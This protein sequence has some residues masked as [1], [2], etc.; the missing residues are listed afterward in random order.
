ME[1]GK[2][3][4]KIL[5][6]INKTRDDYRNVKGKLFERLISAFLKNQSYRVIERLR[7]VGTEID[8]L[9]QNEL[10]S[11]KVVVEC[12]TQSEALNTA[13]INKLHTDVSLHDASN[14]WIF[15]LSDLGAEAAGRLRKLNQK[16]DNNTYKFIDA[17]ELIGVLSKCGAIR[18][19]QFETEERASEIFLCVLEHNIIWVVPSRDSTSNRP[20]GL[21]AWDA[22]NGKPIEVNECP[23]FQ[24]SDFPF[25]ELKWLSHSRL[26]LEK[27]KENQPVVEV[28]P[29]EEWSD[30]RPSRPDDFVGRKG[31]IA[32]ISTFFDRVRSGATQ[33][34]LF[35]IKGQSGWGKSSLAL[36][37]AHDLLNQKVIVVPV[38]CRAAKASYYP[39]LVIAKSPIQ[40][41][42]IARNALPTAA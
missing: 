8:L 6:P 27:E 37:L 9:C 24:G 2:T 40:K 41:F 17:N 4:Y 7:D 20:S 10:S 1:Y 35:G 33:S 32:E 11:S 42:F 38:D 15:A 13:V 18:E 34:R 19:P 30:Y 25:P 31:L 5:I 14:G 16:S 3:K 26:T 12:K 36:K 22:E 23:D 39:D 21:R 28:I 29:G